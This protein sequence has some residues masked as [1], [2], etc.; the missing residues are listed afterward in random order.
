MFQ[1]LQPSDPYSENSTV[2]TWKDIDDK[3]I[4][5]DALHRLFTDHYA[6]YD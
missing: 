1:Q 5:L 4:D 3:Q 6:I 2:V